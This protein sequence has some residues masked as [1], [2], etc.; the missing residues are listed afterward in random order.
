M[1]TVFGTGP[2]FFAAKTDRVSASVPPKTVRIYCA[3]LEAYDIP[4]EDGAMDN[5]KFTLLPAMADK[6][7]ELAQALLDLAQV[8]GSNREF[9]TQTA[10][11]AL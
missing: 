1:K 2:G 6:N 10:G 8:I 11:G 7:P 4:A 5:L 9:L 3:R